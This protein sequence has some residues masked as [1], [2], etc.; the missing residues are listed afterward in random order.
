MSSMFRTKAE[1]LQF[2]QRKVN[3]AVVLDLLIFTYADWKS[4]KSKVLQ[5][6]K[7]YFGGSAS[8]IIRS[9]ALTE[10]NAQSSNAGKYSSVLNVDVFN[11]E[12]SI[13]IVIDSYG[14]K[15]GE[16][17]QFFVQP[18]LDDVC[19]SGVM[20]A[21]D[22]ITGA[23]Y[24]IINF[25]TKGDTTAVTSGV[26]T[27]LNTFI[28]SKSVKEHKNDFFNKLISLAKE[29]ENIFGQPN[30]D[31]EFAFDGKKQL[32]LLQSRTLVV[33][34][35]HYINDCE[36]HEILKCISNK[37]KSLNKKHPYLQGDYT[38]LGVMP[39]WNPAEIIGVRPKPLAL[40]LYKELI[41]NNVWAYQRDNYGYKN[42]RSFPLL[43]DLY[44]LPYI[45]VRV[46]FNSFLPKSLN[47][48][49]SNKLVNYYL[50][51]LTHDN[52]LH[53]KVEFGIIYSCYTFD[54]DKRIERLKNYGFSENE[55][56][57]IVHSLRELTNNIIHKNKGL[58]L[59]DEEKIEILKKRHSYIFDNNDLDEIAKIYWL[60]EDC[61]RYGT[62]P[63]A[64]LARAGFIAMQ[65]LDSM[66]SEEILT[67]E[68]KFIFLNSLN[69]VSSQMTSDIASLDKEKFLKKY[70][71]LRPGTYDILSPRYDE[72]PDLYFDWS[73][74]RKLMSADF[75]EFSLS[76]K[77]M[78]K[79]ESRLGKLGL[80]QDVIGLFEFLKAAIEGREYA[81]F[82]F[83]KH[84]S[85]I[86]LLIKRIGK[87]YNLEP[88]DMSYLE[89]WDLLKF[90]GTC[91]DFK[92]S[93][94]E[95]IRVGR[96]KYKQTSQII[97]P[98]V[99]NSDEDIWS[100]ELPENKPNFITHKAITAP[101]LKDLNDINLM[102]GSIV[103][104]PSA[105]PGYDWIFTK[106]IAGFITG[107]GGVNSHMAIRAGELGLPAVIGA[108][109]KLYNKWADASKLYL[110]C[111]NQKVEV[112]N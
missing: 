52:A 97:L 111:A 30:L 38:I 90:Y 8:L 106:G 81:K 67:N 99:I 46:S 64:G 62:L 35:S 10:D 58:W 93:L 95:S 33:N 63:F 71:H 50:S 44:G 73:D 109:E 102:E 85:D 112:I 1:T 66:V 42:L 34:S 68:Q 78:K 20:F 54:L 19:M 103:F 27:L 18:M 2:L 7:K 40:S 15:I 100:F 92:S 12:K 53:D 43:I 98:S 69:S 48:D 84:L 24:Y 77:Q 57:T 13:N 61:K 96:E 82:V 72:S 47:D 70:G 74:K 79:I 65:I 45:D 107:Y 55:I 29:I 88:V 32:Y 41:T 5:K 22:P 21:S 26:K 16:R 25:E 9:S 108:G 75:H 14:S 76:L 11:L 3:T 6:I 36:H 23:P 91:G 51:C 4:N 86:L 28:I 56:S 94:M 17:D 110:D 101:I 80:S 39:D 59:K 89:V 37:I 83:T 31:I 105:D 60:V 87:K 49:L 104:I